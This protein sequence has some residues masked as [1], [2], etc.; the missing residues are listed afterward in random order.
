MFST[1]IRTVIDCN[2]ESSRFDHAK[3]D[4]DHDRRKDLD[5]DRRKVLDYDQ[6]IY[7]RLRKVIDY[8]RQLLLTLLKFSTTIDN[9]LSCSSSRLRSRNSP[10]LQ[11]ITVLDHVWKLLDYDHEY[12]YHNSY[13][14]TMFYISKIWFA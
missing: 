11:S 8:D 12:L 6:I 1:S 3:K 9:I 4:L 2:R 13:T 5:H 14:S 7:S 10:R